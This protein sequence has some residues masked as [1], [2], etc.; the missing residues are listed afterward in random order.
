[1]QTNGDLIGRSAAFVWHPYYWLLA[2]VTKAERGIRPELK[3][4]SIELSLI[5]YRIRKEE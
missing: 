5:L 4:E 1:M 2:F 3:N